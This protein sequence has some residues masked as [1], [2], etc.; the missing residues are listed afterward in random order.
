MVNVTQRA[1][2]RVLL[3]DDHRG[4]LERVAL[5]LRED[6]DVAGVATDG[7]QAVEMAARLAPDA[8][9][10]DINMPGLDGYQTKSA[11]DRAGCTAP[12]VFLS[13]LDSDEHVGE[14]FRLGG[15]G[16]VLKPHLVRDLP[17]ALQHV[18]HGRRFVPSLASLFHLDDARGHAMQL[19]SDQ[20]SFIDGLADYFAR[21]LRHGDATCII[22][23]DAIRTGLAERL[24][25]RGWNVDP[26]AGHPRFLAIDAAA[27]LAR[28]MRDQR[29]DPSRVAEIAAEL[30]Q[31]RMAASE[32]STPR[33]T[34]FANVVSLL[35][36]SNPQAAIDLERTWNGATATL[37]FFTLCGY[38]ASC[39]H[40]VG[41]ETS[42]ACAAH[43]T[44]S[45]ADCV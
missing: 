35:S 45:H 25:R 15:R 4:M 11:L 38:S 23:T 41:G 43:C 37:P 36:A 27:A 19:Y 16:Y 34:M 6:V 22:A 14:A 10:L 13:M 32:T 8:I 2:P 40:D 3:I 33:L 20:D 42:E 17:R 28:V 31:Y 9:V 24:R 39:F 18:L 26:Q 30:E 1:R 5:L 44:V 12:V 7:R 29:P 21:S